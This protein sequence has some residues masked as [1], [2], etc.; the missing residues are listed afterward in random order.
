LPN[1]E[2]QP[3]ARAAVRPWLWV[4]LV[5]VIIAAVIAEGLAYYA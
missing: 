2:R 1:I 5:F 4:A 3:K